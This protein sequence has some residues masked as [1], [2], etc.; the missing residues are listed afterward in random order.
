MILRQVKAIFDSGGLTAARVEPVSMLGE[1]DW[2]LFFAT[3]KGEEFSLSLD[4]GGE[5]KFKTPNAA[6]NAAA[7][8]GFDQV[9]VAGLQKR[10]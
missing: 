5:R 9:L 10:K 6:L 1:T 3:A 4:A 2:L 8:V 7:Q